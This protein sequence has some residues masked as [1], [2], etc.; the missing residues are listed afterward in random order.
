MTGRGDLPRVPV[1]I[2]TYNR[3]DMFGEAIQSVFNQTNTGWE[4]IGVDDSSTNDTARIVA[5]I[6]KRARYIRQNNADVCMAQCRLCSV[7]W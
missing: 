5:E 1:I 3:T 7:A 2:P 4:L 6:G